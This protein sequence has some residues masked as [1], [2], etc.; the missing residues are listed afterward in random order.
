MSIDVIILAAGSGSRMR[1]RVPDKVLADLCGEPVLFHSVR[2][3]RQAG[4]VGKFIFVCRDEAQETLVRQMVE[5]L[6]LAAVA[7]VR[8]GA[9]RQDSVKAGLR[10]VSP[11]AR[12][13]AIHD[14][15]RPLIA[16]EVIVEAFRRAEADGAAV[17]ARR[18][19][20]TIKRV[21]L[22]ASPS[23]VM[24]EDLDR[25]RL[26]A[27]ETPQ[28][29][30]RDWIEQAYDTVLG[31]VTDDAAALAQQGHPVSLVEN[32]FPNPKITRPEDLAWAT[33]LLEGAES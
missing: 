2:A 21:P 14:G 19:V 15:A 16:A 7:F 10:V 8:G 28:I 1:G 27:M 4:S 26:W 20:D 12:W 29:F 32:H 9:E 22:R 6:G 31:G 33:F 30:R 5:K 23:K 17:V 24:L 13:V 3:F 25:S 18:V 11:D